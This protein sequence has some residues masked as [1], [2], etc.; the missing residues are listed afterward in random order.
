MFK[1]ISIAV[2]TFLL[3]VFIGQVTVS[4]ADLKNVKDIGKYLSDNEATNLQ[5]DI[6]G[7]VKKYGLDVVVVITKDTEGKSSRD[8]ADDYYDSKGYGVGND[9]SGLLMLIN[10]GKREVWIS[11]TGKAIDIF[12]DSRISSMVKNVTTPLSSAKYYDA[13]ST[14]LKD[15]KNYA[16]MGV[17]T[18][19]SRVANSVTNV[20]VKK[21]YF[22]KVLIM[23]KTTFVYI[24][25]LLIA[26]AAILI[27]SLSNKGK[28]T[29]T[30][31]TYESQG[32]FSITHTNDD[33]IR[34]HTTCTKVKKDSDNNSSTH[35][36][37]S[38]ETHGGGGGSF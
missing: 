33:Y 19:Q 7:V 9:H 30:S 24:A 14:F 26:L 25:S 32:S 34:E 6:D 2:Y 23:T 20:V 15:V 1:K 16:N 4:A 3:V 5:T 31:K 38:G 37:S 12:T 13:C 17:P 27:A 35:S 11:T 36:S 10:M 29:I 28:V 22:Q 18:G 8:F 21:T